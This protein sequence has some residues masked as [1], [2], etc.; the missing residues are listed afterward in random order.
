MFVPRL[1]HKNLP[2]TPD[3]TGLPLRPSEVVNQPERLGAAWLTR[4]SF[5][6]LMMKRIC[7]N[8][9]H[10]KRTHVNIDPNGQ[11]EIV[12]HIR[13]HER[14]LHFVVISNCLSEEEREDRVIANRWDA[15][16]ALC[17]GEMTPERLDA[18]RNE[19][20]R[21]EYGRAD[22]DTLVWSRGN[23]SSRF[24]N[25]VVDCLAEGQQPDVNRLA[26][27]GYILRSTAYYANAK[28][29]LASFAAIEPD[30]ALAG[31]FQ[32]QMFAAF[33]FREFSC[34][35][36]EQMALQRNANAAP[37]D[38]AVRRY[39]GIGNATGLG[40]VPFSINH[41]L[42][43]HTW[44][45]VREV[46]LARSKDR[47]PA[48]A[49]VERMASLIDHAITYFREDTTDT[50]EIFTAASTLIET[51]ENFAGLVDEYQ[52][53]RTINSVRTDKPWQA[54]CDAAEQFDLES[55][56]LLHTLLIEL[57]PEHSADL[58]AQL[59][60]SEQYDI[61]PSMTTAELLDIIAHDYQWVDDIS[62]D[63]IEA[64]HY[65]W[66]ISADSE[67]P[68]IGVR[69]QDDGE[70]FER[71]L[72]IPHQV[73]H[74]VELLESTPPTW[75]I[76]YFLLHHPDQR[77]IVQRIQSLHGYPYAE[78]RTNLLGADLIPLHLQRFQLAMYGMERFS[79]QS[80]NW[81]RVT[82]L[83]GAPI[84]ADVNDGHSGDWFLP[85]KPTFNDR[86]DA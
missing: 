52:R 18:I 71:P 30:H 49:D 75:T 53:Q 66:Y 9:W 33:L 5:S 81:V 1:S 11:G 3:V 59:N 6:R 7:N 22:Q 15:A 70:A 78:P 2:P 51:L 61:A 46:A 58:E 34:D 60:I 13:T 76:G 12:Y 45:L 64:R 63:A 4:L 16:A 38:P 72:D 44:S 55:Q 28:F 73:Q 43:T 83:Q 20:V 32:A 31:S 40:L 79:P 29:G 54:L 86:S 10:I 69:G 65:F 25:Y 67:E 8:G 37:L 84:V 68:L 19:V 17:Q 41:P 82:L 42:L 48:P 74:L 62:T 85:L 21:Q 57:Y 27:G 36:A 24:F 14:D 80:I 39:L 35:L 47:S 23:R 26:H 77:G 56:E 50:K